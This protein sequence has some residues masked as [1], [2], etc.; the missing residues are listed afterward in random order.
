[1]I[2][3]R[4]TFS[5]GIDAFGATANPLRGGRPALRPAESVPADPASASYTAAQS[6]RFGL[7]WDPRPKKRMESGTTGYALRSEAAPATSP[8]GC[9]LWRPVS[10][11]EQICPGR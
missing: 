2:A 9:L 1:M 4:S 8:H 10:L 3:G 5:I 7:R 6:V 11:P